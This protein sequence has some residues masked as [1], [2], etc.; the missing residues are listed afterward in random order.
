[1]KI[2]FIL[3]YSIEELFNF[4][5]FKSQMTISSAVNLS[6]NKTPEK[7]SRFSGSDNRIWNTPYAPLPF[8]FKPDST[9]FRPADRNTL[10]HDPSGV[11]TPTLKKRVTQGAQAA[12]LLAGALLLSRFRSSAVIREHLIPTDWKVWGKAGMGIGAISQATQALNWKPPLWLNAM[13][14]VALIHP[15]I[16]GFSRQ[17]ARKVLVLAPMVAG[18]VQGTSWLSQ[19]AEETLQ[20]NANIP[21][22]A[23][24]LSLSAGMMAVGLFGF[25]PLLKSL[26]RNGAMGQAAKKELQQAEKLILEQGKESLG[27]AKQAALHASNQVA[28]LTTCVRGCCAGSAVCISELGEF[29][30]AIWAWLSHPE[31]KKKETGK[32]S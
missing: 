13:G 10:P 25:P 26:T 5:L 16:A 28:A 24:K 27:K 17:S 29:G 11:E 22:L 23:T 18:L 19:K 6:Y 2:I 21:P 20:D 3:I 31:N 32:L 30:S 14:T 12:G 8:S 1:M 7:H 4:G 15:L 9:A